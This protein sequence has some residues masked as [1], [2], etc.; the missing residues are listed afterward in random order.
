V[1]VI[2]QYESMIDLLEDRE[3]ELDAQLG[4]RIQE[5]RE[6]YARGEGRDFQAV[7]REV[8]TAADIER[9][10]AHFRA[11]LLTAFPGQIR[12]VILYGSTARGDARPD[13]DVDVLIVVTWPEARS[14][15]GR[16]AGFFND[17]RIDA[18][19]EFAVDAMLECGRAVTP[20]V[21]SM[22]HFASDRGVAAEA[23]HEG[24]ELLAPMRDQVRE[25]AEDYRVDDRSPADQPGVWLALA[26]DKL[27]AARFLEQAQLF[28]DAISRGYYAML[29]AAKAALLSAGVR[30]KS[31]SGAVAEFGRVFVVTG[32]VDRRYAALFARSLRER[33][34]SDYE[35]LLRAA[36]PEAAAAL[37]AAAEFIAMVRT[38]IE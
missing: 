29:Y 23:R 37:A 38:L 24:R 10:L 21:L 17:A 28:D 1:P 12:H 25:P 34:H 8:E 2:D 26:D 7:S 36:Q 3:D 35:P 15:D 13:S 32:R 5:E 27:R 19:D 6:S 20:F 18:I 4:R 11:R 22:A 31:H 30:V 14:A 33:I 9:A 16:Y